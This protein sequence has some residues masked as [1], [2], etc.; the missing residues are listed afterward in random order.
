MA[1]IYISA[2]TADF[3]HYDDLADWIAA[4][5]ELPIGAEMAVAWITPDF[6]LP[7]KSMPL[8]FSISSKK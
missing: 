1:E 7:F 3:R 8:V 5:P 6:Y 4:F 2:F